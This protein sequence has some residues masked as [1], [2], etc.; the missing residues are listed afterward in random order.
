M[1]KQNF[2]KESQKMENIKLINADLKAARTEFHEL[3]VF[4]RCGNL[5]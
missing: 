3:F 4:V 5:L 2:L 1:I